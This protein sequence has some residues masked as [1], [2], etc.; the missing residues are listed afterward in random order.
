VPGDESVG[1]RFRSRDPDSLGA[2]AERILTDDA[3][4]DRLVAEAQ[5]H[6]L[7]FD[8]ADVARQAALVYREAANAVGADT[9]HR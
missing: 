6:V 7:T 2:M 4:R 3:L 5:E 1:L 9:M 8:W